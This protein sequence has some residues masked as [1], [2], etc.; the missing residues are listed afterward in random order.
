MENSK[1]IFLQTC[2]LQAFLIFHAILLS[3][4]LED[5]AFTHSSLWF[6]G[7]FQTWGLTKG[8]LPPSYIPSPFS[9]LRQGFTNLPRLASKPVIALPQLPTRLAVQARATMPNSC[10][11]LDFYCDFTFTTECTFPC[12]WFYFLYFPF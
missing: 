5:T 1:I 3:A 4:L 11:I 9:S 8:A 10:A 12:F 2:L 6:G 7:C